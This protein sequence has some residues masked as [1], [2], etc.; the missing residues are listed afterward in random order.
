M[1]KRIVFR[2][3]MDYNIHG[4]I[5]SQ[6][7]LPSSLHGLILCFVLILGT[8]H[9]Q[10]T[11]ESSNYEK[12]SQHILGIIEYVSG[13][14]TQQDI[15]VYS[16]RIGYGSFLFKNVSLSTF[17]DVS[18]T[19]GFYFVKTDEKEEYQEAE[20]FG[21]GTSFLLRWYAIRIGK[22]RI[23][24]DASAGILYSFKSFPPKGT[25]LNFT[26]RP[27]IG[28]ATK[29]HQNLNLIA[30]LNRFHLSNGQGYKHPH[31]PAFDGLGI[32]VGFVLRSN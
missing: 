24:L 32:H 15:T 19:D 25:K 8:V 20:S 16:F 29:L 30:G 11:G 28:I 7:G 3:R 12:G 27:G 31:N 22:T 18:A 6:P 17:F 23:F 13:F 14:D 10:S 9:G 1:A 4:I 2:E 5:P 21:L 26:T